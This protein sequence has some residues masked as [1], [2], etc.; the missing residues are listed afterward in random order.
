[1]SM[2]LVIADYWGQTNSG[3]NIFEILQDPET[4]GL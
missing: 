3:K 4:I 1:M 2:I